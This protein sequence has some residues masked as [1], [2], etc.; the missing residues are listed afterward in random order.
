M[1]EFKPLQFYSYDWS[2]KDIDP[3]K[4]ISPPYD[5]LS[6]ED[7]Q[8]LARDEY[9]VVHIDSPVSYDHARE[10]LDQWIK[11]QVLTADQQPGYYI[12]ASEYKTRGKSRTR[13][14][15]MG[16]LRLEPFGENVFPH[17]E[18]YPKAKEDRLNLMQATQGQLSPVF[19]VYDDPEQYVE[20]IGEICSGQ[21]PIISFTQEDGVYN[22]L[23]PVPAEHNPQIQSLMQDRKIFI[24]DGHHR[25]ET[26]LYFMHNQPARDN[27]P[28]EYIFIYLS[29]ISSPGLEIF[30]YHRTVSWDKEFDWQKV[31]ESAG[32]YF[33]IIPR[34]D[35]SFPEEMPRTDM[36]MLCLPHINYL[37]IPR[38][39]GEDIFDKIGAYV[40]DRVMLR[41]I[42]GLDDEQLASG[43]Y[44][45]YTHEEDQT[46]EKVR[47][48]ELQAAF[49]LQSVPINIM[50][51]ACQ[52]G[53]VMPRKSTFFYPKLPTGMLFHLWDR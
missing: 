6:R 41:D 18:T 40:L 33:D 43:K 26:S 31:M 34:E 42:M 14:G 29:N 16:G 20:K 8:E 48:G 36:L 2:R 5:V 10:L 50:Q 47:S 49:F 46:L 32:R 38:Q 9:N 23:W 11:K 35:P 24:A 45:H 15:I 17:E 51:E 53:R 37:L 7:I 12:L 39:P 21:K 52:A 4:V 13:W 28:W 44:L 30:P 22:R 27:A 25:Y 1:P 19:G 3:E